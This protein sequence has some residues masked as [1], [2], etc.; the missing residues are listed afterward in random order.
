MKIKNLKNTFITKLAKN[1]PDSEIES[2]FYL[3]TEKHLQVQRIDLA[4][5]PEMEL[6]PNKEKY[7][8]NAL[9]LLINEVPIQ[10]ILGKTEFYGLSFLVN[11]H[12]LIPRPETEE[13]VDW[14]IHESKNPKRKDK[15][16]NF[17][18][19]LDIGTG[20]GCISISLAKHIDNSEVWAIDI[21]E[22]ALRVAKKNATLNNVQV[23]FNEINILNDIK[24]NR[25]FDTIVSNPP[26]V[27]EFEKKQM[28]NNVL[29]HEP[30]QALFVSNENPLIFYNKIADFAKIHLNNNGSLFLEINESLL[31]ETVELLKEK[32]FE[33]VEIKKDIFGKDR[34][35]KACLLPIN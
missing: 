23:N 2:F 20:S 22:K 21:S 11:E 29:L 31:A 28:S 9:S 32:K 7:F 34:M 30:H 6:N 1:F 17:R 16:K 24:L 8:K 10:Y 3:L 27:R 35:I 19:V 5:D 15:S 33:I 25:Q 18:T 4:L 26:Y 13:L 14:I 12:V